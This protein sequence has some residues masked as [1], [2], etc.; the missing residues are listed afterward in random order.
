MERLEDGRD[1]TLFDPQ[2][3]PALGCCFGNDFFATYCEYERTVTPIAVVPAKELWKTICEAQQ[4]SGTP[5]ILYGDA[6]NRT[7]A[8]QSDCLRTNSVFP[9]ARQEQS[10]ATRDDTLLQPVHRDCSIHVVGTHSC[11]H[12]RVYRASSAHRGQ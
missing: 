3:V 7:S 11:V 6:V 12:A 1:W 9:D 10:E 2:D 5:Y 4:E 8:F